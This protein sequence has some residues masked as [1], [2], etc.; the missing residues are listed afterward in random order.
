MQGERFGDG[1][2]GCC[3][4]HRLVRPVEVVV[5]LEPAER[6]AQV[7]LVPNEGAGQEFVA[8]IWTQRSMMAFMR[9]IRTPVRTTRIPASLSVSSKR[10]GVLRV[11]VPDQVRDGGVSVSQ[12]RGQ[13][14]GGLSQPGRGGV[15]GGAE[16]SDAAGGVL[17]DREVVLASAG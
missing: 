7:V 5:Q 16:D 2:Q 14:A 8:E 4:V 9:G 10:A 1:A 15:R 17:D 11:P 3:L 6:V 13:V 12:V